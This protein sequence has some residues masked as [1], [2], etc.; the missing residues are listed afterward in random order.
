MLTTDQLEEAVLSLLCFSNEQA[1]MIGLR[2]TDANIFSN[3]TN[4]AIAKAALAYIERYQSPPG[5]QLEI[6]LENQIRRGGEEGK[7]VAQTLGLLTK[8]ASQYATEFVIEELDHF[9]D[10]QKFQAS[11]ERALELSAQGDLTAAKEAA[12]QQISIQSTGSP[13]IWLNNPAQAL[14]FLNQ[15]E[16]NEFFSSSVDVLDRRGIR[17]ERKTFFLVIAP[18]KRG[19][20][21]AETELVILPNGNR[22]TIKEAVENKISSVL[23][24][25]EKQKSFVEMPVTEFWKNGKKKCYKVTTAIG[26][27]ITISEEQPLLTEFGWKQVKDLQSNIDRITLASS[28]SNL[29]KK[30][31]PHEHVRLLAYLLA[32]GCLVN[33]ACYTFTNEDFDIQ[34][35]FEHCVNFLGDSIS[36][37][38]NSK[39]PWDSGFCYIVNNKENKF[40]HDKRNVTKLISDAGLAGKKSNVK[41]IPSVVF[42]LT[43]GLIAEFLSVFFSCDGSIYSHETNNPIIDVNLA[44]EGLIEDISYLLTRL[45][46]ISRVKKYTAEFNGKFLPGY[47]ECSISGRMQV[48]KFID[49]IGFVIKK[50]IARSKT[51]LKRLG[52]NKVV[53]YSRN[54]T[55]TYRDKER[56]V[57]YIRN[58]KRI[59]YKSPKRN[60]I[61]KAGNFSYTTKQRFPNGCKKISDTAFFDTIKK[62]EYVGELETYDL[63]INEVHNFLVNCIVTHNSWMLTNIGKGGIQHHHKVLHITLEMS[64]EKTARRY[65]QSIFSL[66]KDEAQ[67]VKVPLFLRDATSNT[68]SIDFRDL[69]RQGI[70]QKRR[71]IAQ[72]LISMNPQLLI[73]EFPTGSLSLQH[74]GL[75]LDSLE[76]I[77]WKPDL[78]IVDYADLMKIA[79]ED[80]RVQT[81]Q[82]YKGLRG[83]AVSR[84]LALASA[85]QGNR[86]SEEAKLVTSKHVAEDWSKIGTVDNAVTYNQTPE[87]RKMNLARL[88]VSAARDDEDRFLV[89]VSQAYAIGQF[90][91]DSVLMTSDLAN[92]ISQATAS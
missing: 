58:G 5:A 3:K 16:E 73:K 70:P 24:F 39:S 82:L 69:T 12:Y 86:D 85:S 49:K 71:E 52:S 60:T 11:L 14:S 17:P 21:I 84:E 35:D 72:Q 59:V 25:S 8:R 87:E 42:E 56:E 20:C 55:V 74:L 6:L 64:E 4:A 83:L 68:Y 29:G 19:K 54:Q 10:T 66:T 33:P 7:L 18:A 90:C 27:E 46:I 31:I 88:F 28:L 23:S 75:Y 67:L 53:T 26:R 47:A 57:S 22:V 30:E 15:R 81:G 2:I 76:R 41:R 13:G 37:P 65:I 36:F 62:I 63:S 32:E 80:L 89:L 38:K 44:S 9:I 61:C 51:V 92:S 43:D 48:M 91:I 78:L 50:K 79:S 77:H 1:A 40:K 34:K 45:G